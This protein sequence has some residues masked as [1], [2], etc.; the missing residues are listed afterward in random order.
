LQKLLLPLLLLLFP[1][2]AAVLLLLALLLLLLLLLRFLCVLL[3]RRGEVVERSKRVRGLSIHT[4]VG[5]AQEQNSPFRTLPRM[6]PVVWF[7]S[8]PSLSLRTETAMPSFF[9]ASDHTTPPHTTLNTTNRK[10]CH[11]YGHRTWTR[12]SGIRCQLRSNWSWP[13]LL[14]LGKEEE[15][16]EEEGLARVR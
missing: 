14:G 10:W 16:E 12:L 2:F 5:D 15:E 6:V 11:R 13:R 3:Y 9:H 1:L 7:S 8:P 4:H